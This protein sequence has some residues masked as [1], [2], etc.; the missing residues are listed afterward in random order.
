VRVLDK[1]RLRKRIDTLDADA[2][3]LLDE[4]LAAVLGLH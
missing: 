4:A 1:S 2:L 3:L